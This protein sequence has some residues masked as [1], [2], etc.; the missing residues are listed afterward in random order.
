MRS[1]HGS[2]KRIYVMQAAMRALECNVKKD[3]V[4]KLMYEYSK[5]DNDEIGHDEFFQISTSLNHPC[6]ELK[7]NLALVKNLDRTMLMELEVYLALTRINV[8]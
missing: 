3:E 4:Q 8:I 7:Y 1:H 2:L 5:E 6:D